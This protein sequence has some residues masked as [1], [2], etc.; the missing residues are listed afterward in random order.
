MMARTFAQKERGMKGIGLSAAMI[1]M[2]FALVACGGGDSGGGEGSCSVNCGYVGGP[3]NIT[4]Y[5]FISKE[6]CIQKGKSASC[7][8]TY[9]PPEGDGECVEVYP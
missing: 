1:V 2:I 3:I 7:R 6:S 5:R 9:C 4:Q 8:A